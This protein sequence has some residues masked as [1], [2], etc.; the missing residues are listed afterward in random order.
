MNKKTY[1]Y[2]KVLQVKMTEQNNNYL[3]YNLY[4]DS[5]VDYSRYEQI[6]ILK[7]I[8][9]LPLSDKLLK[10]IEEYQIKYLEFGVD[11][12]HPI[13]N[14]PACVE[15][16]FFHP[17]SKFNQP[18]VNLP[19]NLK[20]LILG[21]E[22]WETMEYLPCSLLFLGYHKSK[23]NFIKKYG[24]SQM[25]LDKVINTNLPKLLYISIPYDVAT[26]INFSSSIYTKKILKTSSD[27]YERFIE[28]IQDRKYLDYFMV[29]G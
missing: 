9:N 26:K 1:T 17:A 8:E 12:N 23:Q 21:S 28:L 10:Y 24:E 16:I 11:F 29:H 19:A 13:D 6:K 25:N 27:L 2:S 4:L 7:I 14:L 22:Y 5:P 20:T 15:H 18:L 3:H